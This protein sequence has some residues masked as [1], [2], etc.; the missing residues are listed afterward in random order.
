MK[1]ELCTAGA[2]AMSKKEE[3]WYHAEI[4]K[5]VGLI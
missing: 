3:S 1:D 5:L 4:D 2:E